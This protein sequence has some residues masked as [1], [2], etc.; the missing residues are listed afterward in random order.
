M[1][2][3]CEDVVVISQAEK[4][5]DSIVITVNCPDKTGLGC[6]LCRIIL[7][8]GLTLVEEEPVLACEAFLRSLA[9]DA[10]KYSCTVTRTYDLILIGCYIAYDLIMGT[11]ADWWSVGV[12]PFE[13]I[14]GITPFNAEHPQQIFDNI[15]NRKIPWPTVPDE[16]SAEAQ[17]LID[18]LLTKDPHQ[19]LG[20]GGAS[21]V[22]QLI[23]FKDINWDA[24][25]RQRIAAFTK[26]SYFVIALLL[27]A[28]SNAREGRVMIFNLVEAAQEFLSE[29]VPVGQSNESVSFAIYSC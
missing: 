29:I 20:A 11:T 17:D 16:M 19:R 22:K 15:P 4:P 7:L 13:L 12:I 2:I 6:D 5:G 23:F 21:E 28:N 25:A 26:V 1:G 9:K 10:K 14:V 24:L 18:Q 8:F 27:S 3:L